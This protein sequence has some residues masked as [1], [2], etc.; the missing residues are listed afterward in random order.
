MK[1]RTVNGQPSPRSEAE[2]PSRRP[3]PRPGRT[4]DPS[5]L[6]PSGLSSPASPAPA[7]P[8]H[9]TQ[10]RPRPV[11]AC[12]PAPDPASAYR[13]CGLGSR[14]LQVSCEARAGRAG[15]RGA[16]VAEGLV[17]GAVA[18]PGQAARGARRRG[19]RRRR[20]ARGG[21]LGRARGLTWRGHGGRDPRLR[22]GRELALAAVRGHRGAVGPSG[23]LAPR[24][25]CYLQ[26]VPARPSPQRPSALRG[27]VLQQAGGSGLGCRPRCDLGPRPASLSFLSRVLGLRAWV[28]GAAAKR[29][30][31]PRQPARLPERS[32]RARCQCKISG[33]EAAAASSTSSPG[34]AGPRGRHHLPRSSPGPPWRRASVGPQGWRAEMLPLCFL[35]GSLQSAAE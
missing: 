5:P 15:R 19:G 21:G 11:P 31:P 6:P 33:P 14:Q 12:P 2:P 4:K 18:R 9:V 29:S 10:P 32:Q 17:P 26:R 24:R 25:P 7:R 1:G 35:G 8:G 34:R 27:R 22:P 13:K 30:Q 20:E 3:A 28:P 23:L 16:R